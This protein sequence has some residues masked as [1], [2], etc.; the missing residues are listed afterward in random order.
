MCNKP[1][2]LVISAM[3][4]LALAACGKPQIE[5]VIESPPVEGP[6]DIPNPA[7]VYCTGLGY[8]YTTRERKIGEQEPQPEPPA[9]PTPETLEGPHPGMPVVPDYI[10]EVVCVFPD[11]TECEEWEFMSGRCGQEH[12]YC[13]QQGYTLEPG[14]NGAT[15]VFPDGSSCLEIEFFNGDCGPGEQ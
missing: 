3:M 14:A 4:V 11:G 15:C 2:L 9:E 12:S 10:L 6:I 8:E 7:A 1:V 5:T 13:V